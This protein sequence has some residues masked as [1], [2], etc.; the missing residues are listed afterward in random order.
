MLLCKLTGTGKMAKG[1]KGRAKGLQGMYAELF[2]SG[3]DEHNS[4]R[5]GNYHDRFKN[6]LIP[7][8][9]A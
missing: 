6:N 1:L 9:H 7:Y 8:L 2:K 3:G 4:E 5:C